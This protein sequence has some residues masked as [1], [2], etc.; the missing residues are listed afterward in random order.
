MTNAKTF[1]AT[2]HRD[3]VSSRDQTVRKPPDEHI[4]LAIEHSV[5]EGAVSTV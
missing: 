3:R 5:S 1:C 2:D 4:F